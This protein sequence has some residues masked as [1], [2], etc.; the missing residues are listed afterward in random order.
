[1]EE[2]SS[3]LPSPQALENQKHIA[4]IFHLEERPFLSKVQYSGSRLALAETDRKMLEDKK[5]TPGFGKPAD[6]AALQRM[7]SRFAPV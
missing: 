4:L 5:L 3:N 7:P 2:V 6:P 1:V